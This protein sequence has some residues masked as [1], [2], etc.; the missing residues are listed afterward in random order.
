MKSLLAVELLIFL[1][2]L[3]IFSGLIL[4]YILTDCITLTNTI[5]FFFYFFLFC[6][7]Y[8]K[9]LF[10][11]GFFISCLCLTSPCSRCTE[12]WLTKYLII[13]L[14]KDKKHYCLVQPFD[15][16]IHC[17]FF[18]LLLFLILVLKKSLLQS[19]WSKKLTVHPIFRIDI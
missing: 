16:S 11:S 5:F 15:V 6:L 9:F 3:I 12:V 10:L 2:P 4:Y 13:L 18:F 17:A 7:L 8:L 14:R 19:K 1:N